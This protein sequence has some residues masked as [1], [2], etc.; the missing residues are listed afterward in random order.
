[1]SSMRSKRT[2]LY[3]RFRLLLGPILAFVAL[4]SSPATPSALPKDPVPTAGL[5]REFP[6]PLANVRHAVVA[7]QSDQI[8]HGTLIFDKEPILNGAEIAESSPLFEKWTGPGEVFFKIRKNAVAPRHFL[9]SADQGTIAVRYIIIPVNEDRTRVR[10]DAVYVENSHKVVHV[11]DGNVEKNEMKE[12][13][14]RLEA[15]EEA[16][17]I[18]ADEKRRKESAELVH[19]SYVRQRED[20]TSRLNN[21]Q[22]AEKQLQ[23]Q[24]SSLHRELERRVKAPGADMKAAPFQ[25]AATLKTLTAYTQVVVL[26]VTPHWLGVETPDGQRGWLPEGNLELLP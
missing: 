21:A 18:A 16:A 14:D 11:S 10:V 23:Q 3:L 5:V 17:Q 19:Q 15:A 12:I 25:S 1:M 13:K 4:I 6:S 7:V 2:W 8:I 24:V 9:D 20:E 26:I 22:S